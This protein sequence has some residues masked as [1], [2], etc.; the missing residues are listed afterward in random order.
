MSGEEGRVIM[1]IGFKLRKRVIKLIDG[2]G[3]VGLRL[4]L[5]A[6]G[7]SH[8]VSINLYQ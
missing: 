6:A 7:I 5:M 2:V 8:D 4:I 1:D 3:L